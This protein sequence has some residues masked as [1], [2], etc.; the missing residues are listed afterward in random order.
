MDF[1]ISNTAAFAEGA[2]VS[3]YPDRNWPGPTPR[4]GEPIGEPD[5]VAEVSGG[6]LKFE[7]LDEGTF[8]WA[9]AEAEEDWRYINFLTDA[10][11]PGEEE[12]PTSVVAAG[13]VNAEGNVVKGSGNFKVVQAIGG[14]KHRVQIELIDPE[15]ESS[16]ETKNFALCIPV[17][18]LEGIDLCCVTGGSKSIWEIRA[19]TSEGAFSE[20]YA[21]SFILVEIPG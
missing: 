8:Y 3:A 14:E 4:S 21:F 7:G 17:S 9:V 1:V 13:Q 10:P 18:M 12:G 19:T 5:D 15:D 2:T 11:D 20:D 6:I 16:A